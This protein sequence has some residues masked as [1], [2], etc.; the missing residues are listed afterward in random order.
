MTGLPEAWPVLGATTAVAGLV[1]LTSLGSTLTVLLLALA[2]PS[3]AGWRGWAGGQI[4]LSLGML[5]GT[6]RTPDAQLWAVLLGNTL[7]L[8]GT[9]LVLNAFQ[10]FAGEPVRSS[11]V[12]LMAVPLIA[13]ALYMLTSVFPSLPARMVLVW[14]DLGLISGPLL[15]L[16]FRHWRR[17][18][19]LRFAYGLNLAMLVL[20]ALGSL[21]RMVLLRRPPDLAVAFALS[22]PNLLMYAGVLVFSV[23]GTLAFWLLHDD[24]R[25]QEV[26][27]L[28]AELSELTRRDPLTQL[29][30]RRGL[31]EAFADLRSGG[32]ARPAAL[33]LLDIDHFKQLNDRLGHL[34]GD[35]C[36]Q[37]L[38]G[39]LQASTRPSDVVCRTGGDEFVVLLSG[40]TT[41]QAQAVIDRLRRLLGASLSSLPAYTISAGLTEVQPQDT[42]DSAMQRADAALYAVKRQGRNAVQVA[43]PDAVPGWAG[44][45]V[46]P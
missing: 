2:R 17:G 23:G 8:G 11:A 20:G 6:L 18:G 44:A 16:L 37:Q 41:A 14:A 22:A 19:P 30:N 24:R 4:M 3:Y 33:A 21:P 34:T 32:A 27:R 25:R 9:A 29:H 1:W 46:R 15:S 38:G 28:H 43:E 7:L 12:Q 45:F 13:V 26:Q 42:L 36:L 40:A 31:T 5:V 35:H 10:R 39:L